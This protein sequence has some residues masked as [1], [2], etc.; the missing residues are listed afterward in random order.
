MADAGWGSGGRGR[1]GASYKSA[2]STRLPLGGRHED[3]SAEGARIE[4][5]FEIWGHIGPYGKHRVRAYNGGIGAVPPAG[6]RGRARGQGSWTKLPEA[7][8]FF[9]L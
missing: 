5:P 7:E 6:F 4:A 1:P 2:G 3:R 8:H 9:V